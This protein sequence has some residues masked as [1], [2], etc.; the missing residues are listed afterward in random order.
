M[1]SANV[2]LTPAILHPATAASFA[3]I[4]R[5]RLRS[6]LCLVR[7]RSPTR[8][9]GDFPLARWR[10]HFA[11]TFPLGRRGRQ[12]GSFDWLPAD[13]R[14]PA[15]RAAGLAGTGARFRRDEKRLPRLRLPIP[16]LAD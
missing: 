13:P 16:A 6:L 8:G 11:Q 12:T 4:L 15:H 9:M 2:Y 14:Q 7:F 1:W 5:R 3:D 10:F